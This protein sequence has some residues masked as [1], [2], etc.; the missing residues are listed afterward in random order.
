M[1]RRPV[2]AL[3]IPREPDHARERL[4]GATGWPAEV[5]RSGAQRSDRDDRDAVVTHVA[6]AEPD[7]HP[8]D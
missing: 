7:D 6:V 3:R 8:E 4:R 1:I 5:T 2:I